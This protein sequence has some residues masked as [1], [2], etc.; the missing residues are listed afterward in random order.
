MCTNKETITEELLLKL[1][2]E[3]KWDDYNGEVPEFHKGPLKWTSKDQYG[4]NGVWM[5]GPDL[6]YIHQL[7]DIYY[8]LTG[9]ELE[10]RQK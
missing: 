7:K 5:D 9:E 4:I 8:S 10:E 2:F 3:K 1:G 6:T